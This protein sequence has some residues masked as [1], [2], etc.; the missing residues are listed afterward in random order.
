MKDLREEITK[1]LDNHS[2]YAELKSDPVPD[3]RALFNSNLKEE[4]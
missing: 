3:L 1:I 4:K 2:E